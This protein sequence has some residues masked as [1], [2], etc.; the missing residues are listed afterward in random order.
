MRLVYGISYLVSGESD[1][2]PKYQIRDTKK[3]PMAAFCL[4]FR[5]FLAYGNGF[6][7]FAATA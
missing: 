6:S 5:L 7:A 3:R 1:P 4:S 2:I